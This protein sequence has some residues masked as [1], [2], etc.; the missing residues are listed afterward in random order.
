MHIKLICEW[1]G[2]EYWTGNGKAKY[3]CDECRKAA[4]KEKQ[5]EWRDTHKGYA[6]EWRD[7]NPDY[8]KVWAEAHP[9]YDTE[10]A[11]KRRGTAEHKRICP[12]CGKEFTTMLPQ[13]ICCSSECSRKKRNRQ[14][15]RDRRYKKLLE[16]GDI[17]KSI[18][19]DKLIKRDN[20]IC[21]LCGAA[22][23][24]NDYTLING[25]KQV[26]PMYPSIDHVIPVARGGTHTWNN[27]KLAHLMCNV[28]KGAKYYG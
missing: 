13:K 9:G 1:C 25:I 26:G 22:V 12:V 20:G 23:N 16:N 19:L 10:R 18:T 8:G 17:D 15:N 11:R 21:Y 28:K 24:L 3:C 14:H 6:R 7:N 2:A 27:V 5:K 4:Y